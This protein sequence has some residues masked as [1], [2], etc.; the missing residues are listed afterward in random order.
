MLIGS[1]YHLANL[2]VAE[3]L[4]YVLYIS[5]LVLFADTIIQMV[6]FKQSTVVVLLHGVSAII[7]A[8]T[9]F[10]AIIE[11]YLNM[12]TKEPVITPTQPIVFPAIEPGTLVFFLSDIYHYSDLV[13][14]IL[15][16]S[17]TVL[18][19][20]HYFDRLS[21]QGRVKVWALMTAPLIY[22]L[23]SFAGIFDMCSPETDS[24]LFW[25]YIYTS[26]NSAAMLVYCLDFHSG[27]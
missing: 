19:L 5:I 13:S 23:G 4:S 24:E 15:V 20:H 26:L 9:G 7:L 18:L 27:L 11:D 6:S 14:T 12:A 21:R 16:W 8:L 10:V 2:I 1:R 3:F 17:T 22:F 25:F